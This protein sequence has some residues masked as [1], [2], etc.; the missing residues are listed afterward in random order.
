MKNQYQTEIDIKIIDTNCQMKFS[1]F[2]M[3][4][5]IDAIATARYKKKV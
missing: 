1:I 5:F 2:F 3:E 4:I